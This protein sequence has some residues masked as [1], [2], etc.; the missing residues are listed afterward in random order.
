MPTNL[1]IPSIQ[2]QQI[3]GAPPWIA[4][5]LDPLNKNFGALQQVVN[6]G[7]TQPGNLPWQ[8]AT[9]TINQAATGYKATTFA[10][11]TPTKP[12]LVIF[13]GLSSGP[14]PTGPIVVNQWSVRGSSI[15][16]DNVTGLG[17]GTNTLL[18]WVIC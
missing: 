17:T 12:K 3:P 9:V 5:L 16:L 11:K 6:G 10:Y 7:I 8:V 18:L 13:G 4:S 15:S 1:P 14:T 2:L